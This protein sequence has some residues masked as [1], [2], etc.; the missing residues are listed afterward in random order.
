MQPLLNVRQVALLLNVAPRAVYRLV[1]GGLPHVRLDG[2]R[3]RFRE[4]DLE[5]WLTARE[6]V[7]VRPSIPTSSPVSPD[8]PA[9]G[10]APVSWAKRRAS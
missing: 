5:A 8:L 1:T 4:R 3:L 10:L 2:G 7:E 6:R 9:A